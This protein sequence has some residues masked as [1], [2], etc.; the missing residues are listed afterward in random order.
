MNACTAPTDR[1]LVQAYMPQVLARP[2]WLAG[3]L[4]DGGMMK[5]PNVMLPGRGPMPYADVA[6]AAGATFTDG[7]GNLPLCVDGSISTTLPHTG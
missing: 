7:G 3:M 1:V 4:S 2:G 5:F 6:T